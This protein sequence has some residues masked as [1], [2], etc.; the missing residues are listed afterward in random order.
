ME[1]PT[2]ITINFNIHLLTINT[3]HK[4]RKDVEE[5]NNTINQQHL[6]DIIRHSTQ[7]HRICILFKHPWS[8]YSG[9][10]YSGP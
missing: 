8:M 3:R 4:I 2:I 9:R 6:T 1:K 7:L 10:S 5:F